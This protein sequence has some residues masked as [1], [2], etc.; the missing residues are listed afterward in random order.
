MSAEVIKS[1]L[2]SLGFE[3]DQP[4]FTGFQRTLTTLEA[5]VTS[6]VSGVAGEFLKFQLGVTSAFFAAGFGVIGFVDK[7][8][9]SDQQM[10]L[11]AMRSYMTLQQARGVQTAL[12]TLGASLEDVAWDKELHNRF[13]VLIQDQRELSRMLGPQY[14]KQMHDVRDVW[15]Q[16]QRLEV[17]GEYF[18]M[19]FV[20]DLLSKMGFGDGDILRSLERLNDFVLTNMPA[21]SNEL[22]TDVVPILKDFWM[23][24]KDIGGIGEDLAVDFTNLIALLSG[25]SSLNT[26]TFDFHKFASALETVAHWMA[27]VV[28][29]MAEAERLLLAASPLGL[30]SALQGYLPQLGGGEASPAAPAAGT[31]PSVAGS[32]ADQ[33]R[34]A[35]KA[36]S[37]ATG[38]PADL[39]FGQ[40][41]HETG[42][43]TNRGARDLNNLA[44]IRF[45][46]STEYRSFGSVSDFANFYTHLIESRRYTSQGINSARTPEELAHAL[47]MGHYYEGN[48]R[49]YARGVRNF[50][51]QYAGGPGGVSIGTINIPITQPNASAH[52]IHAAVAKGVQAGINERDQRVMAQLNGAYS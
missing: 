1:Y 14:E 28:H 26:A 17:K 5:G 39:I 16:L 42:G 52:E 33:A 23:I 25:D 48:E 51:P 27:I 41:A 12:S 49:D 34:R 50:E 9:M 45:A 43:F 37:N 40:W 44:G 3:T 29:Y 6:T 7:L 8:A 4:A 46:G 18:G 19:K 38:I 21:W 47:K 31:A 10:R 22:A 30:I 32:M 36:V 11:F 35:A 24:L 2:V 20:S 15:F 13:M